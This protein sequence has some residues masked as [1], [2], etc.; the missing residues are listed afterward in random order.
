MAKKKEQDVKALLTDIEKKLD[1]IALLTAFMVPSSA[2]FKKGQ[3]VQFSIAADRAGIT[4]T[5]GRVRKGRVVKVSN[6]P[7]VKVLMDGYKQPHSYNHSFFEPIT[8][9]GAR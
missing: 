4:N 2:R 3:R 8:R 6:G 5:K 7:S 9:R 1:S